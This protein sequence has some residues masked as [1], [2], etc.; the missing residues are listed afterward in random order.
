MKRKSIGAVIFVGAFLCVL[1]AL[2]IGA[3]GGGEDKYTV[4]VPN[5]LSF[6]EF[7]GYEAWQIVS[8]SQNGSLIAA[9]LANPEMIKAYQSGV[10]GNGK[11]SPRAQSWRRSIGTPRNWRRFPLRRC[12]VPSMTSTS[13]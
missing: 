12:Q 9:T 8:I 7:R 6:S 3:E 2:A 4:H 5:G 10:P 1:V 11:P 13:W